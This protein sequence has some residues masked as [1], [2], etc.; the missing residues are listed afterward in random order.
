MRG[1]TPC[2]GEAKNIWN[3]VHIDESKFLRPNRMRPTH[4]C[5]NIE[6]A[7]FYYRLFDEIVSGRNPPSGSE[8]H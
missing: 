4:S 2:V 7:D 1:K 8:G 5:L 3:H 6:A